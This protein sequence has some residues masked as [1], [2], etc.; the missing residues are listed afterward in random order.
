MNTIGNLIGPF[1]QNVL[2]ICSKRHISLN[3]DIENPALKVFNETKLKDFLKNELARA[4]KSCSKGDQITIS[5]KSVAGSNLS[6]VS[7]KNSG[8]SLPDAVKAELQDKGYEVRNRFGYDT[9]ISM[10]L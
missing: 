6:R 3:L 2:I 8:K 10:T 5:E 4:I 1:Y 9:I 7:V